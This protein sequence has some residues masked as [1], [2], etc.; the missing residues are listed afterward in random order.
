[1]ISQNLPPKNKIKTIVAKVISKEPSPWFNAITISKGSKDGII[2]GSAAIVPQGV[3]GKVI[4]V[5]KYYSKV[6][7]ITDRNCSVDAIAQ[8]TRARGIIKGNG[9]NLCYLEYIMNKYNIKNGD[10]IISSG[11]DN[12]YPKGIRIGNCL[13]I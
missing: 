9:D 11:F 3:V 5:S 8:T 4:E 7:L 12:T 10:I 2:K 13:K 6:I 1:M